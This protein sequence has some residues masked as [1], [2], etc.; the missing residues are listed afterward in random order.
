MPNQVAAIVELLAFTQFV[1]PILRL[2][3]GVF[4]P[5]AGIVPPASPGRAALGRDPV[6]G[7][8]PALHPELSPRRL[9][10]LVSRRDRCALLDRQ[11]AA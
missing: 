6:L 8:R 11:D 3:L 2:F 9:S 7:L 10:A 4:E 1:E 5:T